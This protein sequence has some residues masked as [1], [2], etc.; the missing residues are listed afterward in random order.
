MRSVCSTNTYYCSHFLYLLQRT[1]RQFALQTL[2]TTHTFSISSSAPFASLLYKHLLLLTLS[3]S[4]P[5]HPSPVCSTNTYYCSHF[6]Y[7]LQRTL[8]QFALQTL[9]AAH[10]FSI[11]SSAPFASLL[12]KHL[13]LLTL[14]LSP[15]AHPSPVCSTNTYCCSHFLYL[16]QRTLRQFALQTLI[17]AHTFSISSSAP[18]ASLL[19]KHLLLLTLSLSP[20][21]HPSPVC[22]T[23]TYYCSHFLY[24]LQRTLCQFALQTLIAAHTFSISSTAP[25]ASLLY[26]HLLLLTLSLSPPAHPSPVCSTNTYYCSH[27]LY[28]LQRTLRQF[29]LQTLIAAHTFSISSSA[30]FASLLYKHLLLL[31]LSL[32][33]PAHPSPVCSTNT[34][35]CSHFLYL[36]QRTLC[37][38]A[39][40]T[41]IAAHTFSISS[42]APF[43]SL[44]YKHLL[45]L[46][47][48][49]SPP[50]HPSPVCSTNTYYC[51]HFLY[52]LQRTLRQ[53]ALQTLIAAHTFSISS[54]AP[55]ASLLYKHLLLLTL[56]LSPPAHPSP[57][58]STNTYY[59]SHFLYLLQRTLRQFALQTLITAHTFSI[60]SSAP[61]A[62]LLYKHLLL[63]TLSLSPPAHPLPVCST[64]TYCCSHFLYLLQRTLRQ[65]ALQTLITAHTFSISSSAPIASLL[66]KHLLL[67]TLSLS[68]P[69]HP[70]PV[71]ST[72]TYYCS[73]FLYLLQR[74]L[75]Q[76]ALQTLITAHTF[77]ISSSAPFASLLYKHLLLLT[78]SLSPPAHPSPVC[79]TNTYYC[80]HFLYLLQRTLCQF[81][82]QTLIAAHTFSISS[83]APFASLLYKHL[84]LLTLSLS[85]PAHPSPV[86]STNTY[87]CSHFLYLLQCTLRQFALQ[88]LIAAHTF[89][90]S[91]SAPFASLLYKHLLL[92]TL[93]LSPPAHPSPVCS[94]NTYYCS[95]F[96]YLLQRTLC[97]FALQTLIAAHTFSISSTAP[98]ASLLYKH[99]LL[100]TLSL[101]P[102]AHPSPVCSTNTYYCSHFLYLLQRTLR[103]F[104]L[105]TLIAAHTFSISSSAP[106]ASLLYKHLLLLTLSL[107]P[108]A[109]PSPVCSTTPIAAHT[110]SISSSAPFASLLYKHLLLLTLSLSPPAHPSPVCSTNTYY[111]SHFLYLLQRTRRQFA[112]QTLITAHTF[113][114][115]SSAP[116]ASLL[117]KHLLLLT[118]SLSPPAHPSPV[119]STN[120]YCCSHF[121]YL[122]QRTLCQFALQ[123]LIAAH[124]FS[125]SSSA[126]F[127]SLLYK[128]LLLLT[129]SLSP[130]AHPSPVCSTNTYYCSHFLYLLQ[131]TLRQF[132]LQT[133]ITA[134]TFSISST[135]PFA[136]LLYKHLLLLTLSLS[137]PAHPSPVCSTNTY[138]CSHFLYLLHCTLRQFAL[139]TLIT[140]HTFSISSSAPVASLL[141]KHLLLLTLSLSP[142]AHPSPVC[143]TNTYYCSHFLYLLQRTLRQF[144]LQTPIAAH[145]FSIS[146]SAPFASLLYKHLLLLTLS[147]SPPAHPSPVCSTNTYYCSHFLYLLQRTR[148][149]F[150]LQTLITAHTFSISSSAPF[151]S[152][153]YKHLLLLTLSLSPPPHPSP[154][155]STNTYYCSHFLYLLQRTLRQFALQ[156]LIAAHTF[157]ISSTAPFASLLYKHLLLLTL[158]LSPPAHPSPV[159]STNTYCCSHFLYLLHCTL[160]QFALQTLITAHTFSISSSA[161]FASLLYKHLL[162]LTLSLSPPAHPSPVCSTNT[163]CCSH[164]LYLLQRTLRQFALQTPIAAH[165]FSISS[166]APF[167]SLR[168][169]NCMKILF[170]RADGS[171]AKC[172]V[173]RRGALFFAGATSNRTVCPAL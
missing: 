8:R 78:L 22:S 70:S 162:L 54:S 3:L 16:L 122:L 27:F 39:L 107:S 150:A 171:R 9:I 7:L 139:Q 62:S 79:S 47:L 25:V 50:A 97:Q 147:L 165:T 31:T 145:T 169:L 82:L 130:P 18:F 40:Q 29:A 121:L 56:S 86:C 113:S 123:T 141:Y 99:L 155:C 168:L 64:N 55:F 48:S 34:Y 134:H 49:L 100:L 10:T 73:H 85:P 57:V 159:C 5:A 126:P 35:C 43:A 148:R 14:S 77:S 11:S 41:L 143:S 80:S 106:F 67:L 45:L 103:Q 84:L 133:L 129:L 61:F 69:P 6:L 120:T 128:H 116:F 91:S 110:F 87:Y 136:S 81:A 24:L 33:P 164:F 37:Q 102:P 114:I 1:L 68:P 44:L 158:S 66:Y 170:V 138:C 12:Y 58:C 156:T 161:P 119:C 118:L 15:P 94:T 108:P 92:L 152:L 36:L 71:C 72:N 142:P 137:P 117:Y 90:I 63:L 88:T 146:S 89:S 115:S 23:N 76:F 60:S 160:R 127:A 98:V 124:T 163:Y 38:F 20:P 157:S 149:Q 32:S 13:L 83:S 52:L 65:F 21:A 131:R 125:I 151:A 112:L 172:A 42:S 51:S 2:I 109:H 132:A 154:V 75:R 101:S 28:L 46:T 167:A 153:L 96:L 111:C 166:S 95:H 30:P 104:A 19:Y 74:T 140:A 4:P 135:A 144:A 93:S 53:F 173:L 17:T 105:Q 59:C 26:K